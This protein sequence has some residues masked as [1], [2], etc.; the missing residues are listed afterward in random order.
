MSAGLILFRTKRA[1]QNWPNTKQV[2]QSSAGLRAHE[3]FGRAGR[4]DQHV[5]ALR[6]FQ[7]GERP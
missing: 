7:T 4:I 5:D 1:A 6:K 2:K 3:P